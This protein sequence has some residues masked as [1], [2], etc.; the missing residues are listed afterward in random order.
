[1]ISRLFRHASILLV[2]TLLL[3]LLVPAQT[4]AQD[5]KEPVEPSVTETPAQKDPV[6]SSVTPYVLPERQQN[7][8]HLP[9][10]STQPYGT[11]T[12][13][14]VRVQNSSGTTIKYTMKE[15]YQVKWNVLITGG[16]TSGPN[17][18]TWGLSS[19]V[20]NISQAISSQ[21]V[22]ISNEGYFDIVQDFDLVLEEYL[23]VCGVLVDHYYKVRIAEYSAHSPSPNPITSN[24]F[25]DFS[26]FTCEEILYNPAYSIKEIVHPSVEQQYTFIDTFV[27]SIELTMGAPGVDIKGKYEVTTTDETALG[28][29]VPVSTSVNYYV[30]FFYQGRLYFKACTAPLGNFQSNIVG[31][32]N[33]KGQWSSTTSHMGILGTM[34]GTSATRSGF[35]LSN[36]RHDQRFTLESQMII[37]DYGEPDSNEHAAGLV[38]RAGMLGNPEIGSGYVAALTTKG[39]NGQPGIKLFRYA[40]AYTEIAFVPFNVAIGVLYNVK[41]EVTPAPASRIKISVNGTVRMDVADPEPHMVGYAGLAV[42][43]EQAAFNHVN[44]TN[45][46]ST[47]PSGTFITNLENPWIKSPAT[48]SW[49]QTANGLTG[50]GGGDNFFT[51]DTKAANGELSADVTLGVP[52]ETAAQSGHLIFRIQDKVNPAS[53]SYV[54]DLSSYAGGQVQLFKFPYQLIK[55]VKTPISNNQLYKLKVV[56]VGPIIEVYLNNQLVISTIDNTYVDGYVGLNIYS[57]TV[58]FQNVQLVKNNAIANFVTN[59]ADP[60]V[61]SPE[62]GLWVKSPNGLIGSG[63]GDNFYTSNTQAS[64]GELSADVTL[65]VPGETAAQ[66]G[67]LIFRIQD[68]LHPANGSYVLDLSSYEGGQIQLFRF[69]YHLVKNVKTPIVN[70]QLYKLKVVFVG[71]VIEIYVDNQLVLNAVDDTYA[72]G[73]V[74]LNIYNTTATFQNVQFNP[75]SVVENFVTNLADPWV[76]SPETGLWVKHSNGLI[77]SGRGDN[78]YTSNTQATNGELS[79]DI[80]L[81]TKGETAAQ[82]GQLIFR[83]QDKLHPASGSY[84][85]DISSYEGGQIQ[86]FRF[87][88]HLVKNVKTPIVN[89]QLYKLKVVFVGPV[90]EVYLNNQLVLSETDATYVGGYVG[91]NIY[92][93]TATFQNVQF[94]P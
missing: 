48:G 76:K 45:Q 67:Q 55:N 57:S 25:T 92:N 88:Y 24:D 84:V 41:V 32:T 27:S 5:P 75:T 74:G 50:S 22:T 79:A 94:N 86:L 60:W 31:W 2:C 62:T 68:K 35:Y 30:R 18:A 11:V 36:T 21:I 83:I 61:K 6:E 19:E 90:I 8:T 40:S 3:T 20:Q 7:C 73:Y 82:S 29:T 15:T 39:P 28:Y 34:D 26:N 46:G 93:T 72:D 56:F 17:N 9:P 54:V 16:G 47:P 66:S 23:Y 77:G 58:T 33:V 14:L 13:P 89:N 12:L 52:G 65:G 70:N 69:P 4:F 91:L 71:P 49:T 44:L 1:M 42:Y 64:N 51:S 81:G 85:I 80:T 38:F 10:L 43:R 78:F 87:P 59:L 63:R 37:I 53:G